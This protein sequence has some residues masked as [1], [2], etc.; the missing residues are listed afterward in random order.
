M[1]DGGTTLSRAL[2]ADHSATPPLHHPPTQ[3]PVP[4]AAL[5]SAP[6]SHAALPCT[7]HPWVWQRARVDTRPLGRRS[8]LPDFDVSFRRPVALRGHAFSLKQ[9]SLGGRI[10]GNAPPIRAHWPARTQIGVTVE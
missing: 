5:P 7:A 2:P 6:P 10:L 1:P 8:P 4:R 9:L 3:P